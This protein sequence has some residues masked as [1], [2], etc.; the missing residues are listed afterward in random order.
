MDFLVR[1]RTMNL[2]IFFM[3]CHRRSAALLP[4]SVQNQNCPELT[5]LRFFIKN[6]Q[7]EKCDENQYNDL[8]LIYYLKSIFPIERD[9]LRKKKNN[10]GF[11][12]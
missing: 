9:S 6:L 11:H 8:V 1:Q 2:Y 7:T 10:L 4:N 12:S 5:L 3:F